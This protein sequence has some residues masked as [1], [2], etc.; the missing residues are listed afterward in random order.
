MAT[1]TKNERLCGKK[2]VEQLFNEG[3][4]FMAY[5]YRVLIHWV[6]DSNQ[7][8]CQVLVVV[9]KR[10][11]KRAHDRNRIKRQTRE[12]WRHKKELLYQ[13]LI[14]S[15][16]KCHLGLVFVGKQLP[17][18]GELEKGINKLLKELG[19]HVGKNDGTRNDIAN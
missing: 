2:Q 11:F 14:S 6:D 8:P 10:S 7:E 1:F 15:N 3:K 5:P 4:A 12:I 19:N 18:Y 9:S 16:K 17:V 13:E